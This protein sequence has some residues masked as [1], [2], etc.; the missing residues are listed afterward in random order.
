MYSTKN[1]CDNVHS[2]E[3]MIIIY[4]VLLLILHV[5]HMTSDAQ[6]LIVFLISVFLNSRSM[7]EIRQIIV[8]R[9]R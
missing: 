5:G 9:S 3:A 7:E 4:D 1:A 2:C 8:L 6:I